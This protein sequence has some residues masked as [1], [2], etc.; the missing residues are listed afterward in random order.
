M[1]SVTKRPWSYEQIH[2]LVLRKLAPGVQAWEPDVVVAIGGGGFIP[3][4]MLRTVC[5]VPIIA[6]SLELYNDATNTTH[7]TPRKRQWLSEQELRA[8]DG[9][10][11]LIVDEVDDTRTTLAY[12][13]QELRRACT[14]AGIAVAVVHSKRK[15]KAVELPDDVTFFCGASI[16]DV[17]CVYP[18]DATNIRMHTEVAQLFDT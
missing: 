9:K 8:L 10:R 3:A 7:A 1:A 15:K 4:R 6:V 16:H 13:V 14:P 12:C 18:W 17:W 5:R 11:V 2:E